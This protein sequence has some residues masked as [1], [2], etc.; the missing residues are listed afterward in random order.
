[1]GRSRSLLLLSASTPCGLAAPSSPPSPPSSRCG[2]PRPNTTSPV[3]PSST[4]SA[5]KKRTPRRRAFDDSRRC[6]PTVLRLECFHLSAVVLISLASSVAHA[7]AHVPPILI[8]AL[9][10]G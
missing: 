5:S 7:P 4:A 6:Q 9:K 1:M 10:K 3:L 8:Y 2:S